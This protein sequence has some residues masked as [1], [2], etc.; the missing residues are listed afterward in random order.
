MVEAA[1]LKLE[2]L[3]S[4]GCLKILEIV[5]QHGPLNMGLLTRKTGMNHSNVDVHLKKLTKLGLVEEKRYGN[6]R[7]IK[8]RF[9]QIQIQ[10]KRGLRTKITVTN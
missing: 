8:P 2:E 6:I 9:Q 1:R 3:G 7:M 5:C 4:K 10:L